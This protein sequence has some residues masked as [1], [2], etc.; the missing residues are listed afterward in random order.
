MA[1]A[2]RQQWG[3]FFGSSDPP[4]ATRPLRGAQVL[5]HYRCNET[6]GTHPDDPTLEC[7]PE[8][9]LSKLLTVDLEAETAYLTE[10]D[11]ENR[12]EGVDQPFAS[13][14]GYRAPW[15][16]LEDCTKMPKSF[17]RGW[18]EQRSRQMI[19]AINSDTYEEAFDTLRD[20]MKG[21]RSRMH[22]YRAYTLDRIVH[23][24]AEDRVR[25]F[26]PTLRDFERYWGFS[27]PILRL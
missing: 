2:A 5:D 3:V 22:W 4:E 9:D 27:W 16:V 10:T 21:L 17:W 11:K 12:V 23:A 24:A 7:K 14:G 26:C 13:T 25:R 1:T 15:K 8:C 6:T 19:L 20:P 18:E